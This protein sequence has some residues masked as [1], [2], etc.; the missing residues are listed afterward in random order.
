[1]ATRR[2]KEPEKTPPSVSPSKGRELIQ[3]QL[4]E[5]EEVLKSRPFN[6]EAATAWNIHTRSVV[7]KAFGGGSEQLATYGRAGS[8]VSTWLNPSPGELEKMQRDFLESRMTALR[9]FVKI[10]E[11]EID[12]GQNAAAAG[13]SRALDYFDIA[14]V[15]ESGHVINAET[16][17]H[18]EHNAKFCQHCGAPAVLACV[19]PKCSQAIRGVHH[20]ASASSSAP[21]S[22]P[23]HCRECGTAFPWTV[24][25]ARELADVIDDLEEV[26]PEDKASMK[27]HVGD[28]I[29]P[30]AESGRAVRIFKKVL[31]KLGASTQ[32][33]FENVL[34]AVATSYAKEQMGLH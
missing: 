8:R 34:S 15:C 17:E 1:M 31:G 7:E 32:K 16:Q 26:T 14:A 19:N 18:P 22:P 3:R 2:S 12:D 29:C 24:K 11:D 30:T 6:E 9:A 21:W 27:A 25:K 23:A 4:V 13:G 10:L 20:S 33:V 28:I 5:A